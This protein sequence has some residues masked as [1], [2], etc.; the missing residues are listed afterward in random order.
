MSSSSSSSSSGSTLRAFNRS[1][2]QMRIEGVWGGNYARFLPR[3]TA[4]PKS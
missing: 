3:G 2:V 1:W 4:V